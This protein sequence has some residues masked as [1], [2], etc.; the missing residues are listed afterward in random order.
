V[1][2]VH[3]TDPRERGLPP[4]GLVTFED[5]E[6]GQV[7]LVDTASPTF[8]AAFEARAGTRQAA[9]ERDLRASGVDLLTIHADRP[10]IDPLLRFFRM[11]QRRLR[12]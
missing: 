2:A 8:R 4:A 1:V 3:V 10:I 6:T 9:L 5:A 11:R 7:R 12:R